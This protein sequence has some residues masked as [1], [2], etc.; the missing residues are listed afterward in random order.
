MQAHAAALS[1]LL[2]RARVAAES[3]ARG[4]RSLAGKP[5]RPS[6]R[7]RAAG[8]IPGSRLN[9]KLSTDMLHRGESLVDDIRRPVP[10]SNPVKRWRILRGDLVQVTS[11]PEEGKRGR[12][13]EVVRA[14]NRVVVE[15][16]AMT[17]V[18]VPQPAGLSDRNVRTEGTIYMSRVNVVCPT[19]DRPTRVRFAF[20]ED[21]TKVRVSVRSGAI[22]P[23]PDI[24]RKRRTPRPKEDGPKDTPP[25]VVLK[26]TFM[27]EDGLYDN[28]D[29]FKVLLDK[30][31]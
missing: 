25:T 1:P 15:G 2:L 28:Y 18:K 21:G 16:V 13:L 23:R 30:E 6:P 29:G 12:I 14:S 5:G 3:A 7:R 20:L 11:G 19:T 4:T 31:P 24:L 10:V 8:A 22:I 9:G 26:R 27:D 17:D